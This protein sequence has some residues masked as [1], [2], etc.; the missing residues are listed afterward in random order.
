MNYR[1]KKKWKMQM[2]RET[3]RTKQNK[4]RISISNYRHELIAAQHSNSFR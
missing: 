4:L 1:A 2:M 3:H